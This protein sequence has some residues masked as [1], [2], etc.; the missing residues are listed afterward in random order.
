LPLYSFWKHI[1]TQ[2]EAVAK[3]R[4]T[5][6][7]DVYKDAKGYTEVLNELPKLTPEQLNLSIIDLKDLL[8]SKNC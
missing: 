8:K 7:N 5:K 4:A 2:K 6:F 3:G 1:R